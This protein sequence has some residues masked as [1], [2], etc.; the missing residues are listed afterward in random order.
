MEKRYTLITGATGFIGSHV[1]ERL[2]AGSH[3]LVAIVRK[4][5]H[6]KNVEELKRKGIA[7]VEGKFYDRELVENTLN[8]F[9][10]EN[11]VHIAALRGGGAGTKEDYSEINVLGTE[12]LLQ[13][14]LQHNVT[15]FVF[16]S[17]VGVMGTIPDDLPG[18]TATRFHG[19]NLYHESKVRAEKKVHTY[20]EK[21]LDAYILRPAITYGAGD[22]GFPKTLVELVK[23]RLL[24]L[25][26]QDIKIHL[27]DVAALS[28]LVLTILRSDKPQ[29]NTYIA[30][31]ATP[32]SLRALANGIY[33]HY[34]K[35]EYPVFLRVPTT[36]YR[37]LLRCFLLFH[38]EK[39][40]TRL[41]LISHNWYYDIGTTV[42]DLAFKPADTAESFVKS[43]CN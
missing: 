16:I 32:V 26:T 10:I 41:R 33:M 9:P 18:N 25:P 38:N 2:L 14:A 35:K 24:L 1:A 7:L 5:A 43:M 28:D 3:S 22:N 40:E 39:W 42:K 19:D 13:A 34:Y 12:I 6:Y 29:H 4:T 37:A 30:A 20:I 8:D 23:R 17:S 27:L 15:R 11:I 21:G 31:D 36:L